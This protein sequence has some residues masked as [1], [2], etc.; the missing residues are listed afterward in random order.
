MSLLTTTM[1]NK[2]SPKRW[3]ECKQEDTRK[4]KAVRLKSDSS[5]P[6]ASLLSREGLGYCSTSLQAS[7]W[8][9]SL[10]LPSAPDLVC[11]A[12]FL[13][14]AVQV[15]SQQWKADFCSLTYKWRWLSQCIIVRIRCVICK[16]P[17]IQQCS[18]DV[19]SF[20]SLYCLPKGSVLVGVYLLSFYLFSEYLLSAVVL[21]FLSLSWTDDNFVQECYHIV[22]ILVQLGK[23]FNLWDPVGVS[24]KGR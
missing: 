15:G 13:D 11:N 18:L 9:R 10:L 21:I 5:Q 3:L 1:Q 4:L 12:I 14:A 20:S 24:A 16:V 7:S 17:G 8:L 23:L 22:S 19:L 6:H 2:A